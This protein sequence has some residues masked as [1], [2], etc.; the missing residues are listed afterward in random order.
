MKDNYS[1]YTQARY[2][3]ATTGAAKP[4]GFEPSRLQRDGFN[5][6]DGVRFFVIPSSRT[7][8]I[9]D[10]PSTSNVA[11]DGQLPWMFRTHEASVEAGGCN[12]KGTICKH[13]YS[14]KKHYGLIGIDL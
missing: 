14:S 12:T 5:A 2:S 7:N 10:L 6:G 9:L 1:D 3:I 11:R 13:K 8:D 4:A